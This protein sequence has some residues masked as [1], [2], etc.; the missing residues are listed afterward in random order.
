MSLR[1]IINVQLSPLKKR[2][3]DWW[4]RACISDLDMSIEVLHHEIDQ[5][6]NTVSELQKDRMFLTRQLKK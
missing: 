6:L 3:S 5:K 4:I 1:D 2:L